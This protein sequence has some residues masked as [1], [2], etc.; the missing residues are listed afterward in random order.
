MS[1]AKNV[2]AILNQSYGEILL[3]TPSDK[4]RDEELTIQLKKYGYSDEEI[5]RV[6]SGD[7]DDDVVYWETVKYKEE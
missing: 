2:Y 7:F 1:D 4:V 3:V 5:N 6:I